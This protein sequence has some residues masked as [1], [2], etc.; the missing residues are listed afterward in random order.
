MVMTNEEIEAGLKSGQFIK[1]EESYAEPADA[2]ELIVHAICWDN[3]TV[4]ETALLCDCTERH[5]YDVLRKHFRLVSGKLDKIETV[6][7]YDNKD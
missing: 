2:D 6:L 4:A 7:N 5:V 3:A 1:L